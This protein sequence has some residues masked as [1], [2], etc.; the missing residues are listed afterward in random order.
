MLCGFDPDMDGIHIHKLGQVLYCHSLTRK[1]RFDQLDGPG[2]KSFLQKN[3][4]MKR[5]PV[6]FIVENIVSADARKKYSLSGLKSKQRV[7]KVE[8]VGGTQEK[9]DLLLHGESDHYNSEE[10]EQKV[11]GQ[12][13]KWGKLRDHFGPDDNEGEY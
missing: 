7:Y 6:T 2:L 1:D 10:K 11:P 12:P 5:G 3:A 8:E 4:A 13:F 9:R